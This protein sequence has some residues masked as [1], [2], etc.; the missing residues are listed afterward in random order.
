MKQKILPLGFL[1]IICLS[2]QVFP[3]EKEEGKFL[4]RDSKFKLSTF[5]VEINPSTSFSVM[6]NQFVNVSEISGGFILN[7]KFYLAFFS[8]GS[9]K[10]N[11]VRI[12]EPGTPEYDNWKETGVEMDKISEDAEFL[13]VKFKHSGLKLGYM[14]NNYKTVFWRA[15]LQFGFTGGLNMTEEQTFMGLF[16]NLVFETKI[17][18]FEPQFGG[19]VNL[20]PWCRIHFDVGYRLMSV[21]QRIFKS[22]DTD[23]FTF[24][25]GFSF[26]DFKYK[27]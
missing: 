18:I 25:L 12:P 23:S 5:Y 1:F 13:Y 22:T 17:I 3:Q 24:K 8:T 20:L 6:N 16:D 14:H 7:N 26:G 9:P 19:G 2:S 4:F 15:G 11:T 27:L 21:D 10:I